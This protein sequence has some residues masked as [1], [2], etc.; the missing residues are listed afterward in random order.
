MDAVQERKKSMVLVRNRDAHGHSG[1][2]VDGI[3]RSIAGTDWQS[4][5]PYLPI[6]RDR[7]LMPY[8]TSDVQ[9]PPRK[10]QRIDDNI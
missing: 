1:A 3:S 5:L 4:A 10:R 9:E 7:T 6:S 8:S 2:H